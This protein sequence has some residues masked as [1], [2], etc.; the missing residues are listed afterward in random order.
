MEVRLVADPNQVLFFNQS[1]PY[2]VA[3]PVEGGDECTVFEFR[4]DLLREVIGV[5][6]PQVEERPDRL[7][8]FRFACIPARNRAGTN[9]KKQRMKTKTNKCPVC[10]WEIKDRGKTVKVRDLSVVVCC[11]DCADKIKANPGKYLLQKV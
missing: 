6:Q 11:D 1:E 7:F 8:E 10:E 3:H 4:P 9:R 2:R 5:Y